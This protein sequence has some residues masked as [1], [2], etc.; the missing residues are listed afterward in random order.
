[1]VSGRKIAYLCA[2]S[3]AI[4]VLLVVVIM[5]LRILKSIASF[6]NPLGP[7]YEI[8]FSF[9]IGLGLS[10]YTEMLHCALQWLHRLF[11]CQMNWRVVE[12]VVVR[13]RVH[14]GFDLYT[15]SD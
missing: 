4:I 5:P 2:I 6:I 10:V 12:L 15:V 14:A 8:L 3:I 13:Y 7:L 11:I 9:H 1:M